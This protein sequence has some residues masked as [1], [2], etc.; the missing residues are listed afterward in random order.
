MPTDSGPTGAA[1]EWLEQVAEA[2][3]RFAEVR[4]RVVARRTLAGSVGARDL[5]STRHLVGKHADRTAA[6]ALRLV[7]DERADLLELAELR[8]RVADGAR[9]CDGVAEAI[10]AKYADALRAR[11]LRRLTSRRAAEA[12]GCTVPTYYARLGVAEDYVSSV[13]IHGAMRGEQ[14]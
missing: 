10:G 14:V 8:A 1:R 7:E 13:G 4:R 2:V 5:A 9:V 11:Y 12:L 3:G 6:A